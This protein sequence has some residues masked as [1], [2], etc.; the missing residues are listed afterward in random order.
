M[1]VVAVVLF[2]IDRHPKW[3]PNCG[4]NK[5]DGPNERLMFY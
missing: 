2:I 3:Q 5:D 1:I 4:R